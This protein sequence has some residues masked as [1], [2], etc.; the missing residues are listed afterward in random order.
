MKLWRSK[1]GD[2]DNLGSYR[3][4]EIHAHDA[5]ALDAVNSELQV[6]CIFVVTGEGDKH[7][8]SMAAGSLSCD[9]PQG[10]AKRNKRLHGLSNTRESL[11]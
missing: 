3:I 9:E 2:L 4:A 10:P 8:R 7:R 1:S 11:A 6:A 5:M